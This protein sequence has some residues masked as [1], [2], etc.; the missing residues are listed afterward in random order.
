MPVPILTVAQMREWERHAWA[1]GAREADVISTV[2]RLAADRVRELT[3]DGDLVLLL[4]GK[5]HNGDDVRAMTPHLAGRKAELVNVL[6]PAQDLAAV[7]A[8]LARRPAWV[9]DGLF[10]IGLNRPLAEEWR[11]VVAAVNDAK[12]PVLAVDVPSGLDADTGSTHG[13]AIAATITV[14]VGSPKTGLLLP[15]ASPW[16]GRLEVLPEVGLGDCPVATEGQWTLASDFGGFPPRRPAGG[17]KGTFGHLTIFAGSS[18]YHG[19]AV[20]AARAAQHAQPGLITLMTSP[21]VYVP[22]AAQLQA[23]MVSAA[24]A[25]AEPPSGTTALLFGPGLAA[26]PARARFGSLLAQAWKAAPVPVIVDASALDWLPPGELP[27]RAIRVITPHPGEAARLLQ[28]T[29]AA[30]QQDRLAAVHKLSRRFGDCWVVLKGR[31]TVIGRSEGTFFVNS[32][33][34]PYLAQGGSGDALAGYLGG[35]LAQPALQADPVTAL[36]FAIWEHGAAADR[37]QECQPG[38]TVED[39]VAALGSR[40]RP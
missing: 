11:A 27:A 3:G 16:V 39:L 12:L 2:G 7:R 13:A 25:A 1:A 33:G 30:V 40:S 36:R 31:H 18:G 24:E 4:A 20:L 10:G 21:E 8:A 38:W 5:G 37:L 23:V 28:T 19:A 17:H 9:V 6:A 34:N 35:L 15:D 32:S 29:S 22:V 26:P 14:S